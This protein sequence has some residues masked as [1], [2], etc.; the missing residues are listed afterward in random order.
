MLISYCL[1]VDFLQ[2]QYTV[3]IDYLNFVCLEKFFSY[4]FTL[5]HWT[6]SLYVFEFGN[7]YKFPKQIHEVIG[8]ISMWWMDMD[9][10]TLLKLKQ[11]LCK[12]YDSPRYLAI[13]SALSAQQHQNAW[14][15]FGTGMGNYMNCYYSRLEIERMAGRLYKVFFFAK[16]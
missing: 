8:Y 5:Q 4:P 16:I 15:L 11:F 2:L 14:C 6:V 12:I 3:Q 10:T 9:A 7:V 13:R 1:H